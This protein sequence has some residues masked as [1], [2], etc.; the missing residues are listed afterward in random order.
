[1]DFPIGDVL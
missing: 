1:M